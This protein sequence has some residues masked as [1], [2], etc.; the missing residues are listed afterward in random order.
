MA[1]VKTLIMDKPKI[2]IEVSGGVVQYI[3]ASV[4]M[5]IEVVDYD[6]QDALIGT[7]NEEDYRNICSPD[8]INTEL[9]F[10]EKERE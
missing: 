2:R 8:K 9:T 1:K 4:D 5:E 6:E 7:N 10:V 3:T